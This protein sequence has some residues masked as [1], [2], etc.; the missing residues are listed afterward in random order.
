ME[1]AYLS[2]SLR[3]EHFLE[4]FT[5]NISH[6][7]PNDYADLSVH[8]EGG[9]KVGF[10]PPFSPLL[11]GDAGLHSTGEQVTLSFIRRLA[12]AVRLEKLFGFCG[13][14]NFSNNNISDGDLVDLLQ[15]I[16]VSQCVT[17]TP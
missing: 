5:N 1:A 13:E 2:A 12:E 9:N 6:V 10:T 8:E 14:I 4:S 11:G 16:R 15:A 17:G 3:A 7:Y